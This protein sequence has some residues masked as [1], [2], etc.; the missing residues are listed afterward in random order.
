MIFVAAGSWC[1][2]DFWRRQHE[3]CAVSGAGWLGLGAL[4]AVE[5]AVGR[6]LIGG[7]EQVAFAGLV[8]LALAFETAWYAWRGTNRLTAARAA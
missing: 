8:A 2:L 6:S 1:A 4:T 7:W 3:H 5:A